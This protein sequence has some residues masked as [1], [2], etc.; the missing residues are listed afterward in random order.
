MVMMIEMPFEG[1]DSRGPMQGICKYYLG[2]SLASPG[3]YDVSISNS[4]ANCCYH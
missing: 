2:C 1:E 3:E 4:D